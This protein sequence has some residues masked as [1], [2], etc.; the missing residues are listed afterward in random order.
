MEI[1]WQSLRKKNK[2]CESS[3]RTVVCVCVC[4]G[5]IEGGGDWNQTTSFKIKW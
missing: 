3:V 2:L 1:P 4:V 5:K